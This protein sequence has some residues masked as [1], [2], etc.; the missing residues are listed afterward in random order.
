[1]SSV[2][3]AVSEPRMWS[4]GPIGTLS[5]A[6]AHSSV[7]SYSMETIVSERWPSGAL[8]VTVSP[9][10]RPSS[11]EPSGD[12]VVIQPRSGSAPMVP[13]IAYVWWAPLPPDTV[14]ATYDGDAVRRAWEALRQINQVFTEFRARYIGKCSPVH[15]F[16]HSFDLAVNQIQWSPRPRHARRR[17]RDPRSLFTR[18]H[19]RRLLVRR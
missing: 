1:M 2:A 7:R 12:A 13:T 8:S 16:W 18:A 14:H 10:R 9:L 5:L 4:S 11:A 17:P 3:R 6:I 15:M 19:Q